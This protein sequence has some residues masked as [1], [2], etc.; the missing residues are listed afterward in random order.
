[1]AGVSPEE[2]RGRG[3][4]GIALGVGLRTTEGKMKAALNGKKRQKGSRSIR[5]LKAD[6]SDVQLLIE[7][8]AAL[9]KRV[10]QA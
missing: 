9:T 5:E 6:L 8:M 10:G 7:Q 3:L 1:M 2:P 4:S